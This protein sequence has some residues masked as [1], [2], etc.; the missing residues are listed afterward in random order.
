MISILNDIKDK[1]ILTKDV[2]LISSK[3]IQKFI[4]CFKDLNILD[5]LNTQNEK[6]LQQL[7]INFSNCKI[8]NEIEIYYD[9]ETCKKIAE[10]NKKEENEFIIVNKKFIINMNMNYEDVQ[11]R[12][13][14]VNI[15]KTVD[16]KMKIYFKGNNHLNIQG[17]NGFYEFIYIKEQNNDINKNSKILNVDKIDIKSSDIKKDEKIKVNNDKRN[18]N[19]I[20]N[21]V[22]K[23]F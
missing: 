17:K 5:Y 7:N 3:S 20:K 2:F 18:N 14:T 8:D 13:V 10:N 4:N 11:D 1:E 23:K 21:I 6:F 16:D 19:S 12:Y 9:F 22:I 15:K